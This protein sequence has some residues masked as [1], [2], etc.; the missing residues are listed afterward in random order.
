M[1]VFLLVL[2][3]FLEMYFLRTLL[4]IFW[5]FFDAN[6][7]SRPVNM[8][9]PIYYMIC[10]KG[11]R[12]CRKSSMEHI[13]GSMEGLRPPRTAQHLSHDTYS[14]WVR[15]VIRGHVLVDEAVDVRRGVVDGARCPILC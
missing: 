3:E 14:M 6:S 13:H 12:P 4:I 1:L 2:I 9:A 5:I 15:Y 11:K 7:N 8:L 10:V